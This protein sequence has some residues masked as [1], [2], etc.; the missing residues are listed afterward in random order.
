MNKE[1]IG[2]LGRVFGHKFQSIIIEGGIEVNVTIPSHYY[3]A[4]FPESKTSKYEIRCKRCGCK[5]SEER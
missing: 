5:P 3:T 2:I 4:N 1:C